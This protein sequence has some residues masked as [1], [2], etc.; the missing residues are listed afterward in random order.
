LL[1]LSIA[2]SLPFVQTKIARYATDSLNESFGTNINI[3]KVAITI[4]GSVKL[5]GVLILDHHKDTLIS[6]TRLQTNVLSFQNLA[7]SNLQFGT[8]RAEA[9]HLHIKTY[10][11]EKFTSLDNFVK[12]FDTGKPSTGKF[13][14]RADDLYITNGHFHLTNENAVTPK[15]LD[16]KELNGELGD[17]F[18]KGSDITANIR[19]LS[20]LDHR[21]LMVQNLK[22][23]FTYNKKNIILDQLELVTRESALKGGIKLTFGKNDMK[24]FVNRVDV[25]FDIDRATVS[26]NELNYFYNEF[27]RNQK[28]YLSTHLKGKLN[29]FILHDLKLLDGKD[30]EIIGSINFRHLFDKKGPGFYMNGNFDRISSNYD[31]LKGIMPRI[32]AKS[33]PVIIEKFGRIDVVGD[34][35]LTKKDIKANI[36]LISALGEARTDL[37]VEDYNKPNDATY[38]GTINLN[39]FALGSVIGDKTVGNVTLDL[40]VDGKGFNKQSL[41]TSVKGDVHQFAFNN[42]TFRDIN[43]DGRMKW[44]FFEGTVNSKD[45]NLLLNFEGLADL[46]NSRNKYDFNAQIEYADLKK[47]GLMKNDSIAIVKGNL[48]LNA[49]GNN[50]NDLA[51]TLHATDL[52]F[53]SNRGTFEFNDF[54]VESVFDEENVRTVTFTSPDIIEGYVTGK[55]DVNQ[56][57]KLVENA[58]G[59]L[60]TNYSPHKV[61]S[62]QFLDFNFTIYNKII[63]VLTP[64]VVVAENTKL[65]GHIN[66]D[67]GE[68]NLGFNSPTVTAFKNTFSN[69]LV[70]VN[71]KNPLYNAYVQMDSIR[72]K[73]YTISDFSLINVTQNDTLYL[74]SEF[75]G[76]KEAKDFF[77]LNLYHTIGKDNKSVVGLKKSEVNFKDYL[78]YLNEDDAKDNK[79]VF[80]KKLTDFTIDRIALSHNGQKVELTGE[81]KGKDYKDVKLT[82]DDVDLHKVTPSLDSLRFGGRLNGEVSLKQD[83]KVYQPASSVTI[84]SLSLNQFQLGNLDMQISGDQSFRKFNVNTSLK[85]GE[86][87]TFFTN[88]F[89]EIVDKQTLLSLDT[90]LNN[91]DLSPLEVFLKS[92]FPDIRG[93][94][95]GRATIVGNVRDPEVNGRLYLKDA[96]L[97]VGYLNTDYNFEQDA[98]VDLNQ[99]NFWFRPMRITDTKYGTSGLLDGTVKHKFFKNWE[100]DLKMSADRIVVLDTEDSEEALFYGTAFIKGDANIYGP[101]TGLTINVDAQ[102]SEGTDIKLPINNTAAAGGTAQYIHFRTPEEKKKLLEG[103]VADTRTYNGIEMNFDLDITPAA[104]IEVII[105]KNTGHSLTSRGNGIM[106]LNINTLGKFNMIGDYSVVEGV[107]N[108]RYGGIIDKKFIVKQG[109]SIVWEG[110]PT[111]ARLNLEAIYKTRANPAVLLENQSINRPIDVELSILLQGSLTAP[112]HEFNI[113][114]P[115]VSS[116]LKSDLEYRLSDFDT[117]QNQALSLI[118][119]GSFSSPNSNAN[120]V[121][122]SLFERLSGVFDDLFSDEESKVKVGV[123]YVQAENNPY[124]DNYSQL[125]VTVSSQISDR[126]TVNG[127]VGV[128]VG[129]VSQSQIVGNIEV[130]ARINEE[131]TLRTRVFNRESDINFLGEGIGYTQGVGLTYEVD[132]DTMSELIAKIFGPA[133]KEEETNADDEIPDSEFSPEYIKFQ[134]SR[135]KKKTNPDDNAPE[136]IPETE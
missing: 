99:E 86:T 36:Y 104:K 41:N 10:K 129:G 116:V 60:Y 109:G 45:P 39:D 32:L 47:L 34:V 97:K 96:G 81:L 3:D 6:A 52:Y 89:V 64:D 83:K 30:S 117:R 103:G 50:L 14:M 8:I 88:G 110:D 100:L 128:P 121:Y 13:R 48:I 124:V 66:A 125:G 101:T 16:F 51:G 115:N 77:N 4:F 120:L 23:G 43:V 33:L 73:N 70:D 29:D 35:M 123:N 130:Q 92:V 85:R 12:A 135:N 133:K 26:S 69:I 55:F 44:P 57:P 79:V 49:S 21:G 31:N 106:L 24:D 53:Q 108:F 94:A 1:L 38:T 58:L 111:R 63:E 107:Y 75:K 71:N 65:R 127:G 113:N 11:G 54:M 27:G 56:L 76:G 59:S 126:F 46:S 134:E 93:F 68:F 105:D 118:S 62:G 132:F 90:S 28:F 98:M 9:L 19:K 2:L 15:I 72:V 25:D 82:F 37:A 22:A 17:F 74:R 84:D 40:E 42:Y 20:L 61:K 78:W 122:G 5:K 91:F 112:E 87:E 67:K 18:I 95:S 114:F 102:S 136:P 7:N 131:N 80:N 119:S